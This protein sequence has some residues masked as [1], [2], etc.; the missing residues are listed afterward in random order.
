MTQT[1]DL[2]SFY[3]GHTIV[4][5]QLYDQ[6]AQTLYRL[7]WSMLQDEQAAEDVVQEVFLRAYKARKRFDP[8]KASLGTWLYQIGLNYCR[9]Q[10][11]RKQVF[12]FTWLGTEAESL[13][14]RRPSSNPEV[15]LLHRD[16]QH[17]LW[18]AI[19]GL[20]A[21][22]R[23]VIILHYYLDLPAVEIAKTLDCPEGTIYSR[24]H[25]ARKRL[26]D[27]LSQQGVTLAEVLET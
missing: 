8:A 12:S 6:H 25:N 17:T 11:R 21:R 5:D 13:P 3:Q 26:A 27:H 22:L 14:E 4:F 10:L 20:S 19:N 15:S 18:L 24:L 2:D 1:I 16:D 23:E 9:S 7:G